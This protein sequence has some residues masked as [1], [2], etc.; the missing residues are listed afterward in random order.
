MM[1]KI[2]NLEYIIS[3]SFIEIKQKDYFNSQE[4]LNGKAICE[5]AFTEPQD[6]KNALNS[7]MWCGDLEN[8]LLSDLIQDSYLRKQIFMNINFYPEN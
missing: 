6:L 3:N 7:G 4:I 2:P 8:C 5:I 1:M